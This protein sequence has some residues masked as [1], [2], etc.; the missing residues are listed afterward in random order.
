VIDFR[1]NTN[2]LEIITQE[3]CKDIQNYIRFPG[4][5]CSYH[6]ASATNKSIKGNLFIKQFDST[7]FDYNQCEKY[8]ME[9]FGEQVRNDIIREYKNILA[10]DKNFRH[11]TMIGA[12]SS[13]F[14]TFI[15]IVGVHFFFGNKK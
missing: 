9:I 7:L 5:T 8:I 6:V 4:M 13:V 2:G 1:V 12:L 10:V 15:L 3:M 11:G 14:S